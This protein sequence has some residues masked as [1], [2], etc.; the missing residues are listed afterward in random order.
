MLRQLALTAATPPGNATPDNQTLTSGILQLPPPGKR[1]SLKL[2][3]KLLLSRFPQCL[4][5][6]EAYGFSIGTPPIVTCVL[7]SASR[8]W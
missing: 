3:R 4:A 8:Q 1:R 5:P 7:V 2:P 6:K